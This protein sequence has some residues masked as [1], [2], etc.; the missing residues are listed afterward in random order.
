MKNK[1]FLFVI[2][3]FVLSCGSR[4][5]KVVI[6]ETN[7][8][9]T[10]TSVVTTQRQTK[11]AT[12]SNKKT[13]NTNTNNTYDITV[14][15][16]V[17]SF[18]DVAKN[19]MRSYNIPASI[20]L[21]QGIL[22]S[23]VGNGRLARE[24]NNHFGIKCHGW[25]GEKIYHDDDETQECFRKYPKAEDSYRDHSAFLTG[26]KRYQ[27]LFKLQPNDYQGWATGLRQ[28]GYATDPQ[29]PQKLIS[30][31]ERYNLHKYD[32]EVLADKNNTQDTKNTQ[33]P[34]ITE[35]LPKYYVVKSGDTLFSISK[36]FNTTVEN[37][38]SVNNLVNNNLS[39]GQQLVI[40]SSN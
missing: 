1:I 25:E 27:G 28:A 14:E 18:S 4:K 30:L 32:T 20:T 15:N 17:N 22:E 13:N 38:K 29:Y 16:Y 10:E 36:L 40:P 7:D 35:T 34:T 3:V 11:S 2:S 37:L 24:G 8:Q 31:I 9:R 33:V 5:Y 6:K 39:I 19:H 23:G 21:A 12:R 26:R